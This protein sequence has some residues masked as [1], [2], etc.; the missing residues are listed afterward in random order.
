MLK[1]VNERFCS[2]E[3]G[4]RF[5][6]TWRGVVA[7]AS[8]CVVGIFAFAHIFTTFVPWDDDGY[9]LQ[10]FHDFLS[11]HKLYD[12]VF[13]FY[14]P[15]TFMSAALIARFNP[16]NVNED[17]FRWALWFVW[18]LTALVIAGA[19]WRWTEQFSVTVVVFLIIGFH[20]RGLVKAIGHPQLWIIFAVALLLWLGLDW[21]YMPDKWG[22]ALCT[23]FLIGIIVL[24]KIN[25]GFYVFLAIALAV[26]L[27]LK[28]RVR[29]GASG[30]AVIAAAS[31]AF[32]VLF[33]RL[34]SSEMCFAL[35]YL[36]SLFMIVGA[37][38]FS[39]QWSGVQSGT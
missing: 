23:G 4:R 24:C 39:A 5:N 9:F 14:G 1:D 20:L 21:I 27:Q 22:H 37:L 33:T 35:A 25:I 26:S 11:G 34:S 17:T 28:G 13:A 16:V 7:L 10:A 6:Y 31:L 30:L 32:S 8:L 36:C 38:L 29:L 18:I 2:A 19:V 12:Q 3:L 15:F